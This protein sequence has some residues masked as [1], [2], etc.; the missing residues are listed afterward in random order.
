[1]DDLPQS[2]AGDDGVDAVIVHDTS[3]Q[4]LRSDQV[5]ALERWVVTGGVLVFTG[6]ASALQDASAG[7]GRLLPVQV[8]GMV[9][10]P[11]LAAVPVGG[12]APRRL[13]GRTEL[14]VSR[15][16]SGRLVASDGDL[17]LVVQ[18]RLGRGSVWFLAFDP[19]AEPVASWDGALSMWRGIL[20]DD[21]LPA[22]GAAS[23]PAAEDPWIMGVLAA[24]A[25]AFPPVSAALLFTGAY[26][27]LLVPLLV[28]RPGRSMGARVRL[29]LL[30]IVCA[31]SGASGW[32]AF[33][34]FLFR[35]GLQS[36]DAAR[37]QTRSGDGLAVVTEKVACVA[38]SAQDVE[39]RLGSADAVL[40]AAAYRPRADALPA[41]P[42]LSISQ[43][44]SRAVISGLSVERL[45][46]RLLVAQDVIPFDVTARVQTA[47][48][49]L[50]AVVRNG[51]T[52]PLL[53]CFILAAGRAFPVGD[54]APGAT[55]RRTFSAADGLGSAA[56]GVTA[57]AADSRRAALFKAVSGEEGSPGGSAQLIGWMNGPIL[58]LS[59]VGARTA[60][61]Q[62]GLA[63]V[64][65]E[66]E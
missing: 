13:P 23:R 22:L 44:G 66:A 52:R 21:R 5:D 33:D 16:V 38:S 65:V 56:D 35:P 3:F 12:G 55:V 29:L 2:W 51:N 63:M 4:Q 50:S 10:R 36:L 24:S 57:Q 54:V 39:A 20:G 37:V 18:R 47:A 48:A 11:A 60:G 17:P 45:G 7:L 28:S 34:Y 6:G 32:M 40:E 14:A 1:M 26:V 61:D 58:P 41:E 53:G 19:A 59:F 25:V 62:P 43:T 31:A 46:A 9:Q 49:L 64:S 30:L 27:L 15:L 42:H 8:T